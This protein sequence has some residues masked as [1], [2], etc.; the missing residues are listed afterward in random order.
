MKRMMAVVAA[1]VIFVGSQ[2]G[3]GAAVIKKD[4]TILYGDILSDTEKEVVISMDRKGAKVKVAIARAEIDSVD[5]D[6]KEPLPKPPASQ[7]AEAPRPVAPTPRT[8]P[9]GETPEQ[10]KERIYKETKAAHAAQLQQIR[11]RVAPQ[12][13]TLN[14]SL[15][16]VQ[17]NG[18]VALGTLNDILS[19]QQ[20][21]FD[22]ADLRY[23]TAMLRAT[24]ASAARAQFIHDR[25]CLDIQNAYA[26]SL[27]PQRE[28]VASLAELQGI[29]QRKI[30]PL[31]EELRKAE[32]QLR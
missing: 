25:E 5:K 9:T 26:P 20:A 1:M 31:A 18:R 30:S 28:K 22:A 23:R 13:A 6:A 16:L 14:D 27:I 4:G 32:L 7:P 11:D 17:A 24:P 29:I 3:R 15:E 10:R 2:E 12:L 21:E 8:S 19:H